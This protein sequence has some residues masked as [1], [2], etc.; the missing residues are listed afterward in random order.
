MDLRSEPTDTFQTPARAKAG[1]L[2]MLARKN[3]SPDYPG[4]ATGLHGAYIAE[5]STSHC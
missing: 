5:L 3:S 4:R 2:E 1:Q